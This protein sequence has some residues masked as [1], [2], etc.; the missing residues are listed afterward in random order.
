MGFPKE[1]KIERLLVSDT[2]IIYDSLVTMTEN[3][4]R[5]FGV[6]HLFLSLGMICA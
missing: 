1:K 5:S 6:S 4:K 3:V 2:T